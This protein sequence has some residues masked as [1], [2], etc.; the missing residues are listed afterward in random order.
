[1][2]GFAPTKIANIDLQDSRAN[3]I[4]LITDLLVVR[5]TF[6]EYDAAKWRVVAVA[7]SGVMPF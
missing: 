1:V 4:G 3:I 6:S 7:V 5:T 2:C